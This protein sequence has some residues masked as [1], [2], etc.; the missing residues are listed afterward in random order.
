MKDFEKAIA[1]MNEVK[2]TVIGKDECIV[3]VM[4]ALLAKG[5]VLIEDIPGVGTLFC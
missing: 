2:K 4:C 5:H 3:K 1:V